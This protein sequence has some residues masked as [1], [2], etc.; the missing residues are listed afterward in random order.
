MTRFAIVLAALLLLALS[1]GVTPTQLAR[2]GTVEA[3][4]RGV[5]ERSIMT[6]NPGIGL[7]AD[8]SL[9]ASLAASSDDAA[10]PALLVYLGVVLVGSAVSVALVRRNLGREF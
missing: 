8:S 9:P 7:Q 10:A 5:I 4:G 2:M 3:T 1:G 6:A